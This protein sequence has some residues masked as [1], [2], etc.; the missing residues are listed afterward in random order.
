MTPSGAKMYEGEVCTFKFKCD[1]EEWAGLKEGEFRLQ[2]NGRIIYEKRQGGGGKGNRLFVTVDARPRAGG[3]GNI[4]EDPNGL[5]DKQHA[6]EVERAQHTVECLLSI[7]LGNT[8][9]VALLV[10]QVGEPGDGKL[11][12]FQIPMQWGRFPSQELHGAIES[13]VSLVNPDSVPGEFSNDRGRMSFVKLGGFA[14]YNN[15]NSGFLTEG[16]GGRHTLSSPKRYFWDRDPARLPWMAAKYYKSGDGARIETKAGLLES[17]LARRM[18]GPGRQ[19]HELAAADVLGGMVAELY[20]QACHYAGS[21][22]FKRETGDWRP[23]RITKIHVTYPST[24][25]G[26]ELEEYRARLRDGINAYL[27]CFAGHPGVTL[28]SDI[29]EASSVLSVYAYSEISKT[30]SAIGWLQMAGRKFPLGC[31][32]RVGVIDIGGGTTDLSIS[33]I[34][35]FS[36]NA[37]TDSYSAD[38]DL[39]FRDGMNAAGDKYM[40]DFIDECIAKKGFD[41][42]WEMLGVGDGVMAKEEFIRRYNALGGKQELAELTKTFWYDLAIKIALVCDRELETNGW[43]LPEDFALEVECPVTEVAVDAWSKTFGLVFAGNEGDMPEISMDAKMVITIDR[44]FANGFLRVTERCFRAAARSFALS[45]YAYDADI[46]LFSGK[47]SEFAAVRKVF[48]EAIALPDT[49]ICC[50]KDLDMGAWCGDLTDGKGRITDSKVSTALGGALYALSG[51]GLVNLKFTAGND[52]LNCRWGFV[53]NASGNFTYP[54]FGDGEATKEVPLNCPQR[55][56]ARRMPHARNATLSYE[57]RFKPGVAA[58]HGGAGQNVQV[59]L[60]QDFRT[61]ELRVAGCSG[62]Y[63]DCTEVPIEDIECRICTMSGDFMM[64]KTVELKQ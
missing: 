17:E 8:R 38:I 49:A 45:L 5:V 4:G 7:D 32:V 2:G 3:G 28:D 25:L 27:Q 10:D 63:K 59:T 30:S 55:Y 1:D 22:V 21:E 34:K 12:I 29:D 33:E 54:I 23:R 31:R 36:E 60:E 53:Q 41:A 13:I 52:G 51:M 37:G 47:T 61:N 9:T 40:F 26:H 16:A 48:R 46:L 57:L 58:A 42:F 64:D 62:T 35:A 50:M 44:D 18:A 56:I 15:R 24:L 20:E 6:I 39:T 19:P 14:V 11:P 43:E